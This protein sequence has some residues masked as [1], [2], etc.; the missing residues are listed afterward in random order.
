MRM[1]YLAAFIVFTVF[2]II[3]AISN[4]TVVSFSLQPLPFTLDLPLYLVLFAGIFIGLGA[5]SLVVMSKTIQQSRHNRKQIKIIRDL[6]NLAKN[7]EPPEG[8]GD[9]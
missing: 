2:C 8:S 3:V 9:A 7:P 4:G 6:E 5:G 1:I